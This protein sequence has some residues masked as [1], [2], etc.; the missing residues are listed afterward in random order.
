MCAK[1][2][3]C[4]AV[5]GALVCGQTPDPVDIVKRSVN[6]DQRNDELRRNYTYD[7]FSETREL[8]AAGKPKSIKSTK[9]EVIALGPKRLRLLVERDGKP[10]PPAEARKEKERYDRAAQE[11][12]RMSPA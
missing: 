9:V 5:S 11:A 4:I 1:F 12:A 8:D 10:L 6:V 7:L 2:L 3:F